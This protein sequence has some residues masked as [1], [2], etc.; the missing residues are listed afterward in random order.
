MNTQKKAWKTGEIRVRSVV[1][2]QCQ[3]PGFDKALSLWKILSLDEAGVD[4]ELSIIFLQ[5]LVSLNDFK[6][7]CKK[8]KKLIFVAYSLC[9]RTILRT[10]YL[11]TH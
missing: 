5:L 9:S 4:S 7:K 10:L 11:S 6:T 1:L 2:Q 8:K 3:F